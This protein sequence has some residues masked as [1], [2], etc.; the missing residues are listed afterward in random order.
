MNRGL[1]SG[2]DRLLSGGD[3]AAPVAGACPRPARSMREGEQTTRGAGWTARG[4]GESDHRHPFE[5]R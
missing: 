1:S 5:G 2:G 4:P 3:R